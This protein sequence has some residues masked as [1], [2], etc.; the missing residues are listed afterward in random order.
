MLRHLGKFGPFLPF[1]APP[2]S[3]RAEE[4][5]DE[6]RDSADKDCLVTFG[7]ARVHLA[8]RSDFHG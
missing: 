7:L 5:G 2:L 1:P 8:V 6:S 4:L 3:R